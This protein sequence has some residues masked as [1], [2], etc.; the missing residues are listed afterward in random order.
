MF[1]LGELQLLGV[2]WGE[3]VLHAEGDESGDGESSDERVVRGRVGKDEAVDGGGR[4]HG[5]GT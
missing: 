1:E 3:F 2:W 5:G 4:V